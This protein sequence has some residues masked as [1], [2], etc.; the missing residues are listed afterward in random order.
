MKAIVK[1]AI[2]LGIAGA[3]ALGSIAPSEARS[4]GWVAAGIGL[5]AGAAIASAANAN[6]Y[7]YGYYGPGYA[8][9]AYDPYYA[10]APVYVAPEPVPGYAYGYPTSSD[11][12]RYS[13]YYQ[14]YDSNYIGPHRERQLQGRDY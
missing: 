6:A 2:V 4:R 10:P 11:D 14:G 9:Y 13:P 3:L 1:P 12:A 5:A 8:A 7:Y